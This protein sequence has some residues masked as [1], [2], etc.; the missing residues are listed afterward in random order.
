[1]SSSS[2]NN[3]NDDEE[4]DD[5]QES[6]V[7]KVRTFEW[8]AMY[9]T[10]ISLQS[11]SSIVSNDEEEDPPSILAGRKE[12]VRLSTDSAELSPTGLFQVRGSTD[13]GESGYESDDGEDS[14]TG[15]AD[16]IKDT[17]AEPLETARAVT[18]NVKDKV[19]SQ[20]DVN[21]VCSC[22][23]CTSSPLRWRK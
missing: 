22:D 20:R 9:L 16:R 3:D 14:A 7:A 11:P 5:L 8:Q 17:L 23:L 1:M 2:S 12:K 19:S 13:G 4:A 10:G 18:G 6:R 21:S 15:L